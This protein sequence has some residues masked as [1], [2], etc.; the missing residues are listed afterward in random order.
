MVD[1]I[2]ITECNQIIKLAAS[3]W[4]LI[5]SNGAWDRVLSNL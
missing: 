5:M 3:Q 2:D 4:R 1:L